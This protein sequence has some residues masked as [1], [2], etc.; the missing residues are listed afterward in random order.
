MH[1]SSQRF[2]ALRDPVDLLFARHQPNRGTPVHT[3]IETS[4]SES[5]SLAKACS[6]VSL[7]STTTSCLAAPLA[8]A[9]IRAA[10]RAI[11]DL[12]GIR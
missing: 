4:D 12:L 8:K 5:R 9:L 11:C 3:N 6:G 10:R 2:D 1:R 7:G